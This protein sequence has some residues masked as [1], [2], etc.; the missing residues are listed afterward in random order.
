MTWDGRIRAD[1]RHLPIANESAQCVVTSPPYWGLRRYDVE[2]PQIGNESSIEEYIEQIRAVFREVWRVLKTDGV[3]WLNMGDCYAGA[4]RRDEGFNA[5]WHG[6]HFLTDKQGD[7]ARS[8]PQRMPSLKPKNLIG[9][10][11]R[12]AFALQADG[13]YLRQEIIW[14]KTQ[15]MPESVK[16][17]PTRSH[18]QLF[19]LAKSERYY[20]DAEAIKEPASPDTHAR[21]ARGLSGASAHLGNQTISKTFEHMRKPGVTPKSAERASGIKANEDFHANCSK[22]IVDRVNKRSVWSLGTAAYP[23]AHY[24]TFPPDLVEPCILAGSRPG[25]FVLDPFFGSGTVGMV[26]E[27]FS[28]RWLGCDLGYQD[29]QAKR[30]SKVQKELVMS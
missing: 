7:T 29:L 9:Q 16:D 25:D 18:E 12:V 4:P 24:A 27:R 3:L 6:K 10:P 30:V 19:L 11:W 14:H 28:R 13:W 22:G 15:A 1:A 5:R 2:G 23:E 20:Y 26:A 8:G 17:R 21:Y